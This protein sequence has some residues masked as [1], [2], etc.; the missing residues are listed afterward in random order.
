MSGTT[1]TVRGDAAPEDVFAVLADP[2]RLPTWNA[3]IRQVRDAP[4]ALG[5]GA[6]WVVEMH[7]FGRTW[8]SR[9]RVLELDPVRL[10]FRYRSQ[11]DDGNPSFVDWS[12]TVRPD[13]AGGSV[14]TVGWQL[15][16]KTFWRRVLLSRIRRRQ[17]SRGELPASL[18]AL[19]AVAGAGTTPS[20][21][22]A[23]GGGS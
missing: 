3:A 9:S 10:V 7:A 11:T 17:L 21:G 12:W 15:N 13:G 4:A 1:L 16:P 8:H 23:Y 22:V 5:E 14:T 19:A 2:V 18:L 20:E 6:E